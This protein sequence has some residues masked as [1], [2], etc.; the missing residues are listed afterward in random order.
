MPLESGNPQQRGSES[1]TGD[2]GLMTSGGPGDCLSR[3]K[4]GGSTAEGV[5]EK[6][7]L[8]GPLASYKP[9]K[10]YK[11]VR[12]SHTGANRPRRWVEPTAAPVAALSQAVP[13]ATASKPGPMGYKWQASTFQLDIRRGFLPLRNV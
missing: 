5:L 8:W 4:A 9:Y 7:L 6:R 11:L 1:W 2:T 12:G 13:N 10:S 3:Q